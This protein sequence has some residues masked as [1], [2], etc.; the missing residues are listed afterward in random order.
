MVWNSIAGGSSQVTAL[1]NLN[2]TFN[3]LFY[4][5]EFHSFSIYLIVF[6]SIG[7]EIFNSEER[8]WKI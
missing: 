7:P 2:F 6:S 4:L 8:E 5:S 1:V 3:K